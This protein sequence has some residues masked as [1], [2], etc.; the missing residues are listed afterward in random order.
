MELY[1][2]FA[3]TCVLLL[4][5]YAVVEFILIPKNLQSAILPLELNPAG[6]NFIFIALA[7]GALSG[8]GVGIATQIWPFAVVE[9]IF[10]AVLTVMVIKSRFTY[11]SY[12]VILILTRILY[13]AAT[14][15]LLSK[16]LSN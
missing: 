6:T 11:T 16:T 14:V 7:V 12:H 1:L 9:F 5:A 10:H 3:K 4:A 13:A 8:T 2:L 15:F